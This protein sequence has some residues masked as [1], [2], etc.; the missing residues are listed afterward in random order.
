MKMQEKPARQ[1]LLEPGD[2]GDCLIQYKKTGRLFPY[3]QHLSIVDAFDGHFSS[4]V[5]YSKGF[6]P[7]LAWRPPEPL[8][9]RNRSNCDR[10]YSSAHR[11]RSGSCPGELNRHLCRALASIVVRFSRPAGKKQRT[12]TRSNGVQSMAVEPA[13]SSTLNSNIE[14]LKHRE[15]SKI[16]PGLKFEAPRNN[17]SLVITLPLPD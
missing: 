16:I 11:G 13:P 5:G 3:L 7:P 15:N 14:V 9:M 8:P 4:D 2:C 6:N 17:H 12:I 1:D 10:L